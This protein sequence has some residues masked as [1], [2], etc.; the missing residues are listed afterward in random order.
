MSARAHAARSQPGHAWLAAA[1]PAEARRLRVADPELRA[2]LADAGGE[3]VAVAP[4]VEIARVG[5]R[6]PSILEAVLAEAGLDA[7]WPL[8]RAG[9]LVVP[10]HGGIL[11]VAI[12]PGRLQIEDQAAA[13]DAL[14]A[15]GPGERIASLVPWTL[16]RGRAGLADWSVEQRLSG[17]RPTALDEP[18]LRECLDLLVEL[19][20]LGD[21]VAPGPAAQADFVATVLGRERV[22]GIVELGRRVEDELDGVPRGFGHGDFWAGN[23]LVEGRRLVGV[24]DWDSGG[25]GRLPL[26]DLV[27]LRIAAEAG[28]NPDQWGPTLLRRLLPWADAGGDELSREYCERVGVDAGPERLH[29]LVVAYWLDRVAHQVMYVDRARRTSWMRANVDGVLAELRA[30]TRARG[31]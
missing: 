9:V 30:P 27:H 31:A 11:R 6:G 29:A 26:L 13:L 8:L 2:T 22:E 20:G 17:A 24:I 14:R 1:L 25:P 28:P 3:I 10:A 16:S 5:S 18:L 4:D 12:G 21:G 23:L 7:R 15:A 19:F